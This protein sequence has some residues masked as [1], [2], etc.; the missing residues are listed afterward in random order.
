MIRGQLESQVS[1]LFMF[2]PEIKLKSS[3]SKCLCQLN[4]LLTQNMGCFEIKSPNL[5]LLR[6]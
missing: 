3:E 2:V 6:V 1:P 5:T 4:P